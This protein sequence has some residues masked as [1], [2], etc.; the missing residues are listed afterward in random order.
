M[1]KPIKQ[2]S[3]SRIDVLGLLNGISIW[4]DQYRELKYVRRPF[5]SSIDMRAKILNKHDNPVS[6]TK[7]GLI[8]ALSNEFGFQTYN[9]TDK[10]TFELTY[11][12]TVSGGATTQDV[13]G[14]YKIPGSDTW[15]T[16]TQVWSD[17]YYQS[18]ESKTGFIVWQND[19]ISSDFSEKNFTY[20]NLVEVLEDIP[21]MSELKFI[22]YLV[23]YD[24]ENKAYLLSFTD[25]N[26]PNN[27]NDTTYTYRKKVSS[28][29][30]SG[31][32]AYTLDDIPENIYSGLYFS[33]N[34]KPKELL[35]TIK[36][37]INKK[38]KH[39]WG[40]ITDREC[41]WNVHKL[42][43][44]GHIPHFYDAETPDNSSQY[45][46]Y[47]SGYFGGI[48]ELSDTLYPA[49]I[50]EQ[51]EDAQQWYL[52]IY[53]GK[54]HVDGIPYYFFENP[55]IAHLDLSSGEATLPSGLTRGMYTILAKSGYYDN[56]YNGVRASYLSGVYEDYNYPLGDA[57]EVYWTHIY[58]HKPYLET[59]VLREGEY[60]IDF[61]NQKIYANEVN[62]AIIIWEQVLE[63]SGIMLKY[64]LNPL[65]DQNLSFEKFFLFLT[66]GERN[67]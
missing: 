54:L 48:E 38:F 14:Y 34:G 5:D 21:D 29:S 9:V 41:I 32:V 66:T 3:W 45:S 50:I 43:G 33:S 26:N 37:Y 22:Y 19:K 67:G 8:N 13:L 10:K 12:P 52:K 59:T 28:P 56:P 47:Y 30:L 55:Q 6:T 20:S 4:D 64:D 35:Y 51:D 39:T 16:L 60:N 46:G 17:T 23:S 2:Q 31:I 40:K 44:S 24:E 36:N 53:P 18:K 25:I 27:P 63:P 57:G 15:N 49:E 1:N 7:Q 58:R 62:D 11:N 61:S 42:Y 65:N